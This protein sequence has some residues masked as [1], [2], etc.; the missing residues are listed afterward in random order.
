MTVLLKRNWRR[1]IC[2]AV[3]TAACV[4]LVILLSN[5]G[6]KYHTAQ[7][8]YERRVSNLTARL[9]DQKQSNDEISAAVGRLTQE[10]NILDAKVAENEWFNQFDFIYFDKTLPV[11]LIKTVLTYYQSKDDRDFEAYNSVI[12]EDG[13]Y[14]DSMLGM[15]DLVVLPNMG[16]ELQKIVR[17]VSDGDVADIKKASF[18][19][20]AVVSTYN[21]SLSGEL[22]YLKRENGRWYI[23][24]TD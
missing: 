9:E 21:S 14:R 20:G 6:N 3:L 11:D 8:E 19:G 16:D 17:V 18:E 2:P 4:V 1:L 15:Y 7:S 23:Y 13:P 10:N 12:A 5:L 24:S 22:L